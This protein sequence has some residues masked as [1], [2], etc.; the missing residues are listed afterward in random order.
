MGRRRANATFL[1]SHGADRS[2]AVSFAMDLTPLVRDD[3]LDITGYVTGHVERLKADV[4][5]RLKRHLGA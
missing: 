1:E 3:T 5:A 2:E 4:A